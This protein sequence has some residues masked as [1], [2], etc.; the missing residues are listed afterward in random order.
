MGEKGGKLKYKNV[1]VPIFLMYILGGSYLSS[2]MFLQ[3]NRLGGAM[4]WPNI[5]TNFKKCSI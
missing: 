1:Y 3:N 2:V 5:G 4:E